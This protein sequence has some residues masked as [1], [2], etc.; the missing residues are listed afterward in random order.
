MGPDKYSYSDELLQVVRM[1]SRTRKKNRPILSELRKIVTD[2]ITRI[3]GDPALAA[4]YGQP[5]DL[6]FFDS[7]LDR[8]DYFR[9][10]ANL[11]EAQKRQKEK[12]DREE[13]EELR[14]RQELQALTRQFLISVGVTPAKVDDV[15]WGEA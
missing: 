10:G 12:Y 14:R 1:C 9:V 5:G 15:L 4:K 2:N 11:D 8:H 3:N 13:A 6:Q 7:A